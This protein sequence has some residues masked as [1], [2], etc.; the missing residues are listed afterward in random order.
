M[1]VV[2]ILCLVGLLGLSEWS[3]REDKRILQASLDATAHL[4][5][6]LANEIDE[7]D[8]EIQSYRKFLRSLDQAKTKGETNG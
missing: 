5:K 3:A 6:L 7:L 2:I 4:N 1:S 8:S